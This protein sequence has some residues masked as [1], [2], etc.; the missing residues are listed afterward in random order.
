MRDSSPFEDDVCL[1]GALTVIV[2]C[3]NRSPCG[4]QLAEVRGCGFV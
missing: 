1:K 4:D 3:A 2:R